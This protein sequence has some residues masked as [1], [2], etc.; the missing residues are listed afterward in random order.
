MMAV[1][2]KFAWPKELDETETAGEQ[3][4]EKERQ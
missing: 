4:G 2:V 1:L 3:P